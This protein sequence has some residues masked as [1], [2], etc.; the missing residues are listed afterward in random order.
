MTENIKKTILIFSFFIGLLVTSAGY[1]KTSLNTTIGKTIPEIADENINNALRQCEQDGKYI[2]LSFWST[3]DGLSRQSVNDYTSWLKSNGNNKID[4][5]SV[6]F[7]K[8]ERLF[9]EIVKRDGLFS[10]MQF[11]V[12]GNQAYKLKNEFHLDDGYGSL[13]LDPNGKIIA[14]NPTREQLEDI[15]LC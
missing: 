15:V 3:S 7:D 10:D 11:N 13:L 5:L 2:L 6:N 12:S 14:H 4:L 1:N 8:S 9:Q